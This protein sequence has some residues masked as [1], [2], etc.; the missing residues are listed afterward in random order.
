MISEEAPAEAEAPEDKS[1]LYKKFITLFK[2]RWKS[3][4]YK[5][6]PFVR[7][8]S[9]RRAFFHTDLATVIHGCMTVCK[10]YLLSPDDIIKS[11]SVPSK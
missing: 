11:I 3:F 4:L 10:L 5:R 9:C 6:R 7:V 1:F 2:Y 8:I